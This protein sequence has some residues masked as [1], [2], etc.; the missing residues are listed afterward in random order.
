MA[1]TI[2]KLD[3]LVVKRKFLDQA[4]YASLANLLIH[5]KEL[6]GVMSGS[7]TTNKQVKISAIL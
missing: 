1:C 2:E 6:G 3:A 4:E 5:I 7:G